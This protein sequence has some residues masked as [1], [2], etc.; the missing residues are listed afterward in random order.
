MDQAFF[1][2]DFQT[3]QQRFRAAV[4]ALPGDLHSL[5]LG[6]T[7]SEKASFAIDIAWFGS[8]RPQRAL[9]HVCGIHGIEGFAGSAV[10]LA[11]LDNLPSLSATDALILVHVL[12]PYGMAHL[13]RG[14]ENNV[15]LNRNF[16]FGTDGWHGAPDGY[17]TLNGFLNPPRPPSHLDFFHLRLLLAETSLG[18]GAIRQAVA[19][20]QY[21]FPKG[22]FYGGKTLEEGP[23]LYGE[24]LATHLNEVAELF[25]I[26]VHTGLG[27][28]GHQSLF[29]RSDI[30]AQGLTQS[31]GLPLATDDRQADVMGYEHEGGHGS[32]YRLLLPEA[33]TICVTQ[34]F[35]TYHGRRLLRALR[36][37]N[38]HHHYGDD[39]LDHWSK[40]KLKAM[41]CPEDERWQNQV[42]TQ[43]GDLIH[44]A[45]HLL[46]SGRVDR[47][48]SQP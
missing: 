45:V 44:R 16:F 28:Y 9:I 6:I 5:P 15:D 34:E 41:F 42:T 1:S 37:E 47:L 2:P 48:A 31:L 11:L 43:G 24:W 3:A 19:G 23:K 33:R 21:H 27:G 20:G 22:I 17:A 7:D 29:L 30:D 40:R 39:R 35:G 26:D 25:V 38:Q 8:R 36:A 10:Q 13:R 46:N 12:N 32:I 4:A 18:T 14:N